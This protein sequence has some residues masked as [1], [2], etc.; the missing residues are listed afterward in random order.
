MLQLFKTCKLGAE[1]VDCCEIFKPHYVMLR[2]R[3][4][5]LSSLFQSDP[6][7]HGRLYMSMH[8][9][10]SAVIER[11]KRQ[12]RGRRVV[13]TYYCTADLK[14]DSKLNLKC[15]RPERLSTSPEPCI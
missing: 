14:S 8:Q 2:G 3:C 7:Y 4:F 12:V 11:N 1:V 15:R 9:L 13:T 6:D 5:R 10:P